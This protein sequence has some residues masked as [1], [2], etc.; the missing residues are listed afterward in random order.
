M[1]IDGHSHVFLPT[2]RHITCMDEAGVDKTI[3]F[4][5][6]I[7][8]EIAKDTEAFDKEMSILD[9]TINGR[10]NPIEARLKAMDELYSV[11]KS[12]PFRF[13]GF[14]T[15]PTGLSHEETCT[16]IQNYVVSKNF[17]GL[18]EFTVPSGKVG[19]LE[20]VFSASAEF[21]NLPLWIH[22]FFPLNFSDIREIA[23]L[24]EKYPD[25][26]VIIGHLGGMYWRDT[27]K[28]VK[29]QNNLYV[30]LSAFFTT[31]ALKITM[32][33]LPDKSIF[34][35][36]MPYGDLVVTKQAI[37]RVCENTAVRER[38]LGGTISELLK[39]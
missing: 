25:T 23:A 19:I 8:P 11:I 14:G 34:G 10:R 32:Q 31:I 22:A 33:E 7:H 26:P 3:L 27:I 20:T 38:V 18:G 30:D 17:V 4:S 13:V 28:L 1:V 2:E 16:W 36:D 39:L 24:A 15:V 12:N 35:V 5:T 29:N 37:E 21:G 6:S 9:E